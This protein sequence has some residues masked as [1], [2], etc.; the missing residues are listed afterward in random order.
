MKEKVKGKKKF[1]P[2]IALIFSYLTTL[3][4]AIS[5]Y[6]AQNDFSYLILAVTVP[7]PLFIGI[8]V[9]TIKLMKEKDL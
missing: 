1:I 7:L 3:G 8:L 2:I 4:Y 5:L 6:K 9:A